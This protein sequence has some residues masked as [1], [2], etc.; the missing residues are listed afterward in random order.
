M[1]HNNQ[2]RYPVGEA[3]WIAAGIVMLLAFGDVLVLLALGLAIVGMTA[4]WLAYRKVRHD[5]QDNDA[6]ASVTQIR[7][8]LAT[9]REPKTVTT[10]APWQGP[11]AA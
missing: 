8:A 1:L 9:P 11:S 4:A 6:L 2:S 10:N 3:V 7:P 5:G